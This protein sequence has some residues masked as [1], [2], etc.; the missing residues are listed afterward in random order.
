MHE[1]LITQL[2]KLNALS[3]DPA[4]IRRTRAALVGRQ[5][6]SVPSWLTQPLVQSVGAAFVVLAAA[7]TSSFFASP[8][9]VLSSSLDAQSIAKELRD[10]VDIQVDQ[11]RYESQGSAIVKTSIQ[12]IRNLETGDLRTDL[13]N[14]ELGSFAGDTAPDPIDALLEQITR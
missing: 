12:E 10:V 1:D 5:P 7:A 9:L 6:R 14:T 2:Q 8:S 3:P 11:I 13:L 4:F